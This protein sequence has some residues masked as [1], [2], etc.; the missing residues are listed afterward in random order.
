MHAKQRAAPKVSA[1]QVSDTT[2]DAMR[3]VAGSKKTFT[4]IG[5]TF[6]LFRLFIDA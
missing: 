6:F 5:I 1:V 2:G 4:E 3:I